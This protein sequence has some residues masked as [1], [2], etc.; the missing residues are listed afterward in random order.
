MRKSIIAVGIAA[1]LTLAGCGSSG[2]GSSQ[3]SEQ[4]QPAES[5]TST[6]AGAGET[7]TAES[8]SEES[9]PTKSESQAPT[10]PDGAIW[11][12]AEAD[13]AVAEMVPQKFRDKG[14]ISNANTLAYPPMEYVGKNGE[15]A[16]LNLDLVRAMGRVMNIEINTQQVPFENQIPGLVANRYDI[17]FTTFADTEERRKQ[18]DFVDFMEGGIRVSVTSDNPEDIQGFDDLC[19]VIVGTNKGTMASEYVT[20]ELTKEC[21]AKGAPAP[22]LRVFPDQPAVVLALTNG[23]IEAR[24]DDA[25]TSTFYAE[26]SDGGV[27]SVGDA[28]AVDKLGM[29]ISKD[30]KE[31]AEAARAAIQSMIDSGLYLEILT[32]HGQEMNAI[33]EATINAGN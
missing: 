17:A 10:E 3:T 13:P 8:S 6:D 32:F 2:N 4:T 1:V 22:D 24:I 33:P 7:S 18:V 19:G 9:S 29:A 5:S 25:T 11:E 30:N 20:N 28:R 12:K 31:L 14:A 27:I 21:E 15:L 23:R 26:Q 16:G